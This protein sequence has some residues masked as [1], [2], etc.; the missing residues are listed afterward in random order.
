MGSWSEGGE[1]LKSHDELAISWSEGGPHFPI[2]ERNRII[3]QPDS[4]DLWPLIS[5]E[6]S[7]PVRTEMYLSRTCMFENEYKILN[8]RDKDNIAAG[9]IND[10]GIGDGTLVYSAYNPGYGV[11]AT[12][13]P[14][15]LS[16]LDCSDGCLFDIRQDPRQGLRRAGVP[17]GR[18]EEAVGRRPR[19]PPE[20]AQGSR[21]ARHLGMQGPER[22]QT[23]MRPASWPNPPREGG[24]ND[25]LPDGDESHARPAR[26]TGLDPDPSYRPPTHPTRNSIGPFH[27]VGSHGPVLVTRM[28]CARSARARMRVSRLRTRWLAN[29]KC[30]RR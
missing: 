13:P 8:G 18:L 10:V 2:P 1:K 28:A 7:E 6:S 9:A 20:R 23:S 17:N 16:S 24:K 5:G 12:A 21:H 3:P 14:T 29:G 11:V 27:D 26:D 19:G 25:D 4:K 15:Q 22:L 30:N